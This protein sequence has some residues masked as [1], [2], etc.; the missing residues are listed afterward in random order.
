[1]RAC[2]SFSIGT[3]T[4]RSQPARRTDV[5]EG[6]RHYRLGLFVVTTLAMLAVVLFLL[7]GRQLFQ[8]TFTLETYFDESVSGLEIGAPV[9]FRGV[10]LGQVSEILTSAATYEKDVPIGKR[11]EYIVVRAKINLSADEVRQLERDVGQ[12][13]S[14]GLRARTQ[15]SGLTGQQHLAIDFLDPASAAPLTFEW[16]PQHTYVPSAPSLAG[17]IIENAQ[18]FL[19]GLNEADVKALSSNLNTL[20]VDL[21]RKVKEV[22]AAELAASAR[23]VLHDASATFGRIDRLLAD[24]HL[25]Q[26]IRNLNSAS[27]RIDS[28]LAEGGGID[29]LV[30]DIDQ[31]AQRADALLADNQYDVR[32]IVQDLRT[33]SANLRTLS[34][35]VKRYPAGTLLAGPPD[36]VQL[37]RKAQ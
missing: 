14:R 32:A 26:T 12:M 7:G 33:T 28:L 29:R 25:E 24:G 19:A 22:P 15:L 21:D 5:E 35:S 30:K 23:T 6:K 37:P 36:K 18:T 11:R 27:A 13:V 8:P 2:A 4:R 20:I 17:Q 1:M 31:A 9:R 34:D 3:P 16:T 10:P